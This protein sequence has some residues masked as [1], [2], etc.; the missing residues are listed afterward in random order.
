[1][2]DIKKTKNVT[3]RMKKKMNKTLFSMLTLLA[4]VALV[5]A[6]PVTKGQAL[7]IASKYISNPKL[8]ND[9]PKTRSLDANEQPP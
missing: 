8:S 9:A 5:S 3:N 2:L 7:S 6:N 4:N 1:M